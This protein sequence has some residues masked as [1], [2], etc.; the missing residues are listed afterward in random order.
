MKIAQ[1]L[2]DSNT[3]LKGV[4]KKI[5]HETKEQKGGFLSMLLNTLEASLLGNLLS[6]KG[7]VR[8]REGILRAALIPVHHL[9]NFEIRDSYENDPRFNGVYS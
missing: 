6:G 3:L 7:T 9:T 1:A 8:P 4:T 5:K 2:E